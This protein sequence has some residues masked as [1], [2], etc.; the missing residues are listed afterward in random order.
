MLSGATQGALA[1]TLHGA[2]GRAGW[3][4]AFIINGVCTITVALAAFFLLPGYPERPNPLSRFYLKPRHIEIALARARRVSRKPQIG[5]TLKDF[6]RCFTFWQLWAFGIAWPLAGNT[7]PSNFFNLWLKS[8]R[9]P[10]GTKTYSVAMLNYIPIAGQAVQLVA[11]VLFSGA[12]DYFRK[13]LPFLLLHSAINITSLVIFIIS[14]ES[15]AIHFAGYF[16]NY[17]G[18]VSMIILMAWATENLQHEPQVRT[19]LF[20]SGTV[21]AYVMSA[22][23]PIA[24]FPAVEAPNWRIGSKLYLGF[25]I[26]ATLI[27]FAI[28]YGLR[29]EAR[30]MAKSETDD[31]VAGASDNNNEVTRIGNGEKAFG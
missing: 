9:N 7:V 27:F 31:E 3:R 17:V 8:L 22:F 26:A 24:A 23:I 20:A 30:R 18:A 1:T 14:P 5:I 11:E 29:W 4:W 12:S 2:E 19:M 6:F 21:L 10:D 28:Y 16:L 25:S 13:R 15:R